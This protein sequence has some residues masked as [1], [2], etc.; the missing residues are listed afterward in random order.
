MT[1]G[2]ELRR[3]IFEL[4]GQ[5]ISE[6]SALDDWTSAVIAY[7]FELEASEAFYGLVLLRLSFE[8]KILI[9]RDLFKEMGVDKSFASFLK[10]LD[11][12]RLAR[13]DQ[14]HSTVGGGWHLGDE[15]QGWES[16]YEWHSLQQTKRGFTTEP[17][18]LTDLDAI[19]DAVHAV[20]TE[21]ERVQVAFDARRTGRLPLDDVKAY[22]VYVPG[23][24]SEPFKFEP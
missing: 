11:D 22:D 17:I 24:K 2:P 13:T 20:G 15:A 4:R 5:I 7:Y 6:V 8:A 3:Q 9:L 18:E 23:M 10:E 16:Y 21:T 1:D 12:A 19:L 14:A